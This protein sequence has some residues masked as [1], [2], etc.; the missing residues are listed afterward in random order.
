MPF[1]S[2]PAAAP[3]E[4]ASHARPA[5][6]SG[7]EIETPTPPEHGFMTEAQV[8]PFHRTRP[9]PYS[10]SAKPAS[11]AEKTESARF[12]PLAAGA[13]VAPPSVEAMS[14]VRLDPAVAHAMCGETTFR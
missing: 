13:H 7:N 10:D 4:H 11:G 5:P 8:V 14:L 2:F 12:S 6:P 1:N 9:V 3:H